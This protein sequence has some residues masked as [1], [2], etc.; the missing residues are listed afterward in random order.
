MALS[1]LNIPKIPEIGK[2]EIL[3]LERLSNAHAVSGNEG[4]VRSIV[5]EAIKPFAD[6]IKIDK[7]GN[8]LAT[9]KPQKSPALKVMLAAHM[10]EVGFMITHKEE[11]G[12]YRFEPVGGIDIR[13]IP[14]KAVCIG[15]DHVFGVMGTR[16][17]HLQKKEERK[18]VIEMNDIY[19]DAGENDK[20]TPG[21][22]ASFATL[23]RRIGPSVIGKALDNLLGVATLIELMK[24]APPDIEL[25]A[26][27]TVQ[28]ELG[29]RGA[30]IAAY[31]FNPDMAF[32]IDSTPAR[33]LP[34][35]D[36]SENAN[37]NTRLGY[38]A[39]IYIADSG[40]ISD[41]RLVK[42]LEN[43]A[44]E[45]KIPYQFR[46]PGGGK[47]DAASI[48]LTRA[49]VPSVSVSVPGRYAH[50]AAMLARISDWQSVLAL[51]F[52]ALHSIPQ[53]LLKDPR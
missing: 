9:H 33:D 46:Q 28:E 17:I 10:D 8:V 13:Q 7:M 1:K 18:S 40:T 38:G 27:F 52:A 16:P 35:W 14:G 26:A 32:I 39:A 24:Q 11:G 3:L 47:T 23:F 45:N 20:I 42:Y 41:P 36:H 51:L 22:R 12:F 44:A 49:G 34:S 50:T 2:D 19:I 21:E 5:L 31:T 4:E 6:E 30:Q 43:I 15:K 37:Y 53:D 29:L 25:Q 48:H